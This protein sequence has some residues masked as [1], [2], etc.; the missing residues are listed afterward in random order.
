MRASDTNHANTLKLLRLRYK[1][2]GDG[3][4]GADCGEG[5]G[6][7]SGARAGEANGALLWSGASMVSTY[8]KTDSPKPTPV[9]FDSCNEDSSAADPL[10]TETKRIIRHIATLIGTPRARGVVETMPINSLEMHWKLDET[11]R[12]RPS[13][14]RS[15]TQCSPKL[16]SFNRCNFFALCGFQ[17]RH[18]SQSCSASRVG[19]EETRET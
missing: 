11:L 3:V 14:C 5:V 18:A 10:S 6:D 2:P 16:L 13:G 19:S 7:P 9:K 1:R 12:K 4:G 17:L 15:D 8:A